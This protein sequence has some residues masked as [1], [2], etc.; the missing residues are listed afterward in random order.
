MYICNEKH[1]NKN[2]YVVEK[3][4]NITDSFGNPYYVLKEQEE[5]GLDFLSKAYSV[6]SRDGEY[7]LKLSN[8]FDINDFAVRSSAE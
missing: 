1:L 7:T 4:L 5:D 8:D 3:D 6:V 2:Y